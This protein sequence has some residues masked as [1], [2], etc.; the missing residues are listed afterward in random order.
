[1]AKNNFPAYRRNK[2][3]QFE[4]PIC[5]LVY[6]SYGGMRQ[7]ADADRE[8][9]KHMDGLYLDKAYRSH[10]DEILN[11]DREDH[12]NEIDTHSRWFFIE[13]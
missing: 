8:Y 2:N 11:E 9:R 5:H 3:E 13:F 4:C 7:C 12:S 10:I 6:H 1:M